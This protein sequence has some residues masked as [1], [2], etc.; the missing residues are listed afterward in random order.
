MNERIPRHTLNCQNCGATFSVYNSYLVHKR[1]RRYCSVEC[2]NK[3]YGTNHTYFNPPLTPD[4]LITLGQFIAT[5]FIQN[6]HTIIIRSDQVTIDDIQS[7]IGSRYP[8]EKSDGG[9]LRLKISSSQMVQDLG[10]YGMVHNPMFQEF[11]PYDIL[12]G[13]LKTDCYEM[14]DGVQMF[15]TP[16]SKLSLEVS[17]LVGGTVISETYKDVYKGVLGC[18]WVVVW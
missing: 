16:S 8:I 6:D 18:D 11:I 14:K 9:K 3:R 13:L 10:E 1:P 4:K 7:K 5:G 12:P 15:R 2:V 17:R